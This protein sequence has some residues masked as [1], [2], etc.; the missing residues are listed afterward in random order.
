[1]A[2][3]N[4]TL[5]PNPDKIKNCTFYVAYGTKQGHKEFKQ[6]ITKRTNH[7][8][9]RF[10]PADLTKDEYLYTFRTRQD[11]VKT[12]YDTTPEDFGPKAKL[13]LPDTTELEAPWLLKKDRTNLDET[14]TFDNETDSDT[15]FQTITPRK[16]KNNTKKNIDRQ[17][18]A[19]N[20]ENTTKLTP[21][22]QVKITNHITGFGN[23]LKLK[24]TLKKHIPT[25]TTM[26]IN[27]QNATHKTTTIQF[28]NTD[29]LN[30]FLTKV[31]K[32][33]F[34]PNSDYITTNN[35]TQ[36]GTKKPIQT[37]W[38]GVMRGVDPDITEKDLTDE[39][40]EAQY[41]IKKVSRIT[42]KEGHVTHMVRL[43][44]NDKETTKLAIN[45][46]I[47]LLGRRFRVDP[48]LERYRHIPCQNCCKYG[49]TN[50]EC[51]S[52]KI[53][54]RCGQHPTKCTHAK[55]TNDLNY[56]ATCQTKGHYT[57]Q[58]K[59]PNYPKDAPP[60]LRSTPQWYHRL[61]RPQ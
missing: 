16:K 45:D 27:F 36:N 30:D 22:L 57:G 61:K 24:S 8:L 23:P 39:L 1:M 17:S 40:K 20:P 56:C 51:T 6:K 19:A 3:K 54:H 31:P 48:P 33:E 50:L 14:P 35:W 58:V 44:F 42:S 55:Y 7:G 47:Y 2:E 29:H 37:D 4:M 10:Q 26:P 32:S 34:G 52:P 25:L 60:P 9:D 11:F 5:T 46:G 53:C 41:D 28:Q 59:C 49:H 18:E 38:N 13:Y 21:T 12:T 15:D 43:Y